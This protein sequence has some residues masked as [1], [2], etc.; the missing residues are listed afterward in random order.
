MQPEDLLPHELAASRDEGRDVTALAALWTAAGGDLTPPV[1]GASPEPASPAMRALAV[2][3]LDAADALP[4]VAAADEPDDLAGLRATWP[5]TWSLPTTVSV[6]RMH[7][8]WLGR[9]VGCL[10]GKPVEKISRHGIRE[11]LTATGGWPLRG[12]FTA[13]GLPAEVAQRFPWNRRSAPTSLAENIDGMPEDDDL[14]F[15]LLALRVLETHGRGFTSADVAQAWLDWLPGGR[16]FTAERVAYR[17]LLLGY[18]PPLSARRHNPFREWIGAQ[19]RTDVY[20]WVN[21]G[22]PDLAAELAWRDAVVSHVRG[23]VHGALWAAALA[24]AATVARDVDEVLDAAEAVLPP[25]SRFAATVR[26][27]RVLGAGTDD[28]EAVVDALYARHGHLHWVHVRNNAALVAAA[29]AYGRGDLE[30]SICA[31]VSGGWDTDS[32]GATVGAVTG[33]LTGAAA[34]PER[35]VGPLH[36]RLASSIAGFDGIGFD[37]LAARTLAVAS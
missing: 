35:W 14:N 18:P 32:T 27:A 11:I 30:R 15:A 1:S 13:R 9:A 16:V 25:R 34:L 7:G 8:A 12:Y 21:P 10:L 26:E 31:V 37:E 23:G 4:P 24:A 22:R 33:A 19:I 29:L 3:L 36:N 2:E 20:G 5:A 6:D 28:W 17:N